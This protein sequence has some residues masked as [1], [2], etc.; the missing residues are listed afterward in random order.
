MA[1]YICKR[2]K[3]AFRDDSNIRPE[4]RVRTD[5]D[6]DTMDSLV[7]G[8]EERK[9]CPDCREYR[10][11]ERQEILDEKMQ[12]H[13]QDLSNWETCPFC[14]GRGKLGENNMRCDRCNGIGE[15]F[16]PFKLDHGDV[17]RDFKEKLP[18]DYDKS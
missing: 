15:V 9:Y 16:K 11:S 14:K 12:E 3:N 10:S 6:L 4:N 18:W 1:Q 2:C 17:Q 7:Y 13:R 8:L 5:F